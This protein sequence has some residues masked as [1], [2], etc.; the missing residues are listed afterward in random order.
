MIVKAEPLRSAYEYA[1][2][3]LDK[4]GR[5]REIDR[6]M[7]KAIEETAQSVKGRLYN[8]TRKMY[9]IKRSEFKESDIGVS[10]VSAW[11]PR[12]V[13]RITGATLGLRKAYRTRKNGKRKGASAMVRNDGRMK[14]LILDAGG[15][16]YKA[17]LAVIK[18]KSKD[19]KDSIHKGIFQRDP[20]KFMKKDNRPAAQKRKPTKKRKPKQA[21][22]EIASLSRSKAAEMAYRKK[23]GD[24][25]HSELI[26]H[27]QKCIDEVIGGG[28]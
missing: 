28:K 27:M 13:L 10:R 5:G 1:Y 24:V 2:R 25:A 18:N 16:E 19:G 14:E 11:R 22:N 6:V 4:H 12:A 21:I 26:F 7:Q 9:T 23:V 8:E 3:Q 20:E 17:F 15:K